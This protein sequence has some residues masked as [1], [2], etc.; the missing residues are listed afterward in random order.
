LGFVLGL[1]D[2]GKDDDEMFAALSVG[3]R[4]SLIHSHDLE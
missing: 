1:E 2:D 4:L 3:T